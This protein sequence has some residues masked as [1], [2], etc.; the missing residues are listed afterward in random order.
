MKIA[1]TSFKETCLRDDL[2]TLFFPF[3]KTSSTQN[4][5]ITSDNASV[6]VFFEN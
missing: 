6:L 4:Y 2:L 5:W 1:D 3:F